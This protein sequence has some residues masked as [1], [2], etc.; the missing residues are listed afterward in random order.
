MSDNR[1][2]SILLNA[3]VDAWNEWR[4]QNDEDLA[5][6]LLGAK[7]SWPNRLRKS[8]GGANPTFEPD[9]SGAN[10][11]AMDF[12]GADFS[13]VNLTGADLTESD[14]AGA[15]LLQANLTGANLF[16]ANLR[17][18][19]LTLAKLTRANLSGAN[20]FGANLDK[21]DLCGAQFS[22]AKLSRA[23]L[24][25]TKLSGRKYEDWSSDYAG[26]GFAAANF[27]NADLD[28][29]DLSGAN[30]EFFNFFEANLCRA[31]L[32]GANLSGANLSGA[33]LSEANLNSV[34]FISANISGANLSGAD[35]SKSTFHGTIL[36]DIDLSQ[37]KGLDTCRLLGPCTLDFR[38]LKKSGPLPLVFLR[39]CG[40]SE[41][42]IDYL[43]SLLNSPIEFYSCFISYSHADKVFARRLHDQLQGRGIRCWLD[44]HQ[45]LPGHDIYEEIQRGIKLWDKVLLCC[46]K[47]S[48]TSWWVD[49]EIDLAFAKERQ[50][51]KQR[52]AKVL[53]LIPL[54]L[55]G[56]MF[57]D[58]W[59]SG[60]ADQVKSRITAD[61]SRWENDNEIFERE[62][63]RV[64]KAL[65]FDGGGREPAPLTKL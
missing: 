12:V 27:A 52:N 32:R 11:R 22:R 28:E 45:V 4:K 54:N 19:E 53:A 1:Q 40:L 26:R 23:K 49:N 63:E 33:D 59:Q 5:K 36:S 6:L 44:E 24:T 38:T 15:N 48:L 37:T 64:V 3:G 21:V 42:L 18:A 41:N 17:E 13:E 61:F 50:L 57:S 46:S 29:A 25:E 65:R 51:M 47:A 14:L 16:N 56:F 60:K 58:H 7:P 31:N 8:F 2:L 35:L 39:G 62:I 43:P 34:N 30:L 10:L 9:L 20:L 55:D